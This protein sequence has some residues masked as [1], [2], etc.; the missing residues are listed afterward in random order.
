MTAVASGHVK[1]C[2]HVKD[3]SNIID[4][5]GSIE[6]M[7]HSSVNADIIAVGGKESDLK[8]WNL[9]QKTCT[10]AA[11]NV[12]PDMLQLR[13]PVWISD[14]DFLRDSTKVAVCTRYGHVRV[15][16]PSMPQR[17]PVLNMDFPEQSLTALAVTNR[18]H[19]VVVGSTKGKIMLIDLRRKGSVV[20]Y[21]KGAVGSLKSIACHKSEP[22]IVS[23]GFDRHLLV[24]NLNSR[25][26]L[27]KM[28]MKCLLNC[29]LLRSNAFLKTVDNLCDTKG[30]DDD[31]QIIEDDYDELFNNMETVKEDSPRKKCK[32]K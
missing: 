24:H 25:A 23:V 15:Y 31:I 13:V 21:Y 3:S 4:T 28:Y 6:K 2:S 11:K 14:M 29:I 27:Q 18:D 12:K 20:Q 10:F 19:H 17:R 30:S 26:L 1:V 22:Y 9:E 7:R 8:L 16:D 32:L 5:G